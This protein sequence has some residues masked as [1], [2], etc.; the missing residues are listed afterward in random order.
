MGLKVLVI[1]KRFTY[2][3]V[4]LHLCGVLLLV[5][6]LRRASFS[7]CFVLLLLRIIKLE[8]PEG[9]ISFR[10]LSKVPVAASWPCL[11]SHRH[12][13]LPYKFS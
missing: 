13:G 6:S 3:K 7:F 12:Q 8:T 11:G 1:N 9:I 2:F 5:S 10:N 4:Y